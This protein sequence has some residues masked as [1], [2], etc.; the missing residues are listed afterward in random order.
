MSVQLNSL[1]ASMKFPSVHCLF[2]ASYIPFLS[3]DFCF[4]TCHIS[5]RIARVQPPLFR[6]YLQ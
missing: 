2:P 1:N 3:S 6:Y 5:F 4:H